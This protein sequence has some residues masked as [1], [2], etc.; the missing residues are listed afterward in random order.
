RAR[1]GRDEVLVLRLRGVRIGDVDEG[2]ALVDEDLLGRGEVVERVR[3]VERRSPL[4]RVVAEGDH[5]IRGPIPVAEGAVVGP[6][7]AGDVDGDAVADE[8][9]I[10]RLGKV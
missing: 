7:G 1:G 2:G 6:D 8:A 9:R 3:V 10:E 4:R 5:A